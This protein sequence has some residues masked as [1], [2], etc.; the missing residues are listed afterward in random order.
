MQFIDLCI[1]LGCDY[2]ESIRG[3]GPKRAIELMRQYR[4]IEKII[5]NVDTKKY[6]VPTNWPY[7]QART[8]FKEPEIDDASKIDLVWST[9]DEEA[10]VEYMCK[11]KGF[12]EE[13]VR[14]G[15]KK[16]LKAKQ[17]STQGRLDSFF[18]VLP[19]SNTP[20][21]P[22]DAK[23]DVGKKKAKGSGG[24]FRRGK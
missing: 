20:K 5:A 19:S 13:R 23:K 17:T 21:R 3:I 22:A 16:L 24:S 4:C 2:C 12:F 11:E 14:N 1:L 8:L 6:T 15:C 7:Q 10:L 18:K 9:P